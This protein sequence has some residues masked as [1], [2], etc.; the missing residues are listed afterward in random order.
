MIRLWELLRVLSASLS[1]IVG[2]AGA[3]STLTDVE[4]D[5]FRLATN[6]PPAEIRAAV[7]AGADLEARQ[8][9]LNVSCYGIAPSRER[10][11]ESENSVTP[12]MLASWFG[13][14]D[15][16]EVLIELG[17]NI[18]ART[19]G[20]LSPL[21][22]ASCGR[23]PEVVSVLIAAGANVEAR[24]INGWT[25]LMFASNSLSNPTF[26]WEPH[27]I[28]Q[29]LVR[30][31]ADLEA[32]SGSGRTSL[33][34]AVQTK[35]L[36]S[37][38]VLLDAG[39][40]PNAKTPDEWTP[41]IMAGR[42]GSTEIVKA[43]LAAGANVN[44][45]NSGGYTAL[46]YAAAFATR[47]TVEVLLHAGADTEAQTLHGLTALTYIFIFQDP[48]ERLDRLM[49][50]VEGGANLEARDPGNG[51]TLLH[52]LV[53]SDGTPEEIEALLDA[54]ADPRAVTFDGDS[55]FDLAQQNEALRGTNAFWRLN[56]ARFR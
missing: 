21:M 8:D 10:L 27:K 37:V 11:V 52:W 17:A 42:D 48:G 55:V 32:Q 50:L 13:A 46:M 43:L 36:E 16:V 15:Q 41:I 45:R 30:A 19:D 9:R 22:W 49:T 54:G 18:E 14:I 56:D 35:N 44:A 1:V 53:S 12:L 28:V 6:S 2:F 23:S 31:G 24:S 7:A 4:P 40:D 51:M 25:P 26:G 39:A 20:G 34:Y 3:Q 33:Y 38:R 47:E 5:L 29:A